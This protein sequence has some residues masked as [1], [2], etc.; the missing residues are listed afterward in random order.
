V[1]AQGRGR[2]RQLTDGL[3]IVG[4]RR[5]DR[6][7]GFRP[8]GGLFAVFICLDRFAGGS[9]HLGIHIQLAFTDDFSVITEFEADV[10]SLIGFWR[11][12]IIVGSRRL[13]LI[14]SGGRLRAVGKPSLVFGR[15]G[16]GLVGGLRAV[17]EQAL[18]G[19]GCVVRLLG[20]AA[21]T[22]QRVVR[23]VNFRIGRNLRHSGTSRDLRRATCNRQ[24][25]LLKVKFL[26]LF[27][28]L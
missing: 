1:Q 25:S 11:R 18:E 26:F 6:L 23:G 12:G 4:R 3:N 17:A 5:H 16:C 7:I 13:A 9:G 14:I 24:A 19:G 22:R 15:R 20:R 28:L 8:A 21:H 2:P 10:I 27:S